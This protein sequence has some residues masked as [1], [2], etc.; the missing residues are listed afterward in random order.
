MGLLRRRPRVAR[1]RHRADVEGLARALDHRE[2]VEEGGQQLDYGAD[3]R[4]AAVAALAEIEGDS[5][6]SA[7]ASQALQ[8]PVDEVRRQAV[9]ALASRPGAVDALILGAATWSSSR[10]GES[11]AAAH[12]VVRDLAERDVLPPF[13]VSMALEGEGGELD[14]ADRRAV[15][16]LAQARDAER[17]AAGRALVAVLVREAGAARARAQAI[18][19]L[20]E[21]APVD[22]LLSLLERGDGDQRRRAAE[23]LGAVRSVAALPALE[24]ALRQPDDLPLRRAASRA[25]GELHHPRT[26]PALLDASVDLDYE[27]RRAAIAGLDRL[28][29]VATVAAVSTPISPLM[30]SEVDR[31]GRIRSD[32]RRLLGRPVAA[33]AASASPHQLFPIRFENGA[34]GWFAHWLG[35]RVRRAYPGTSRTP[36]SPK[37][38]ATNVWP[39]PLAV[40][41]SPT[42]KR[43]KAIGDDLPT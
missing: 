22:Q 26:V 29:A 3:V 2:L 7:L 1:L 19:V 43:R 17:E 32:S 41:A 40:G 38:T 37:L 28:G 23:V 30:T 11:R 6:T 4:V 34:L 5:A 15:C 12:R 18:I 36:G 13:V 27:V 35:Q 8:D 14:E 21:T 16:D 9:L 31:V 39:P 25:L 33:I 20:L 42:D 24:Q 10:F